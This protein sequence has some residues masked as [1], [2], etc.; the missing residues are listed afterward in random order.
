[1]KMK[2]TKIMLVDN[3]SSELY[4]ESLFQCIT[5][6]IGPTKFEHVEDGEQAIK[7]LDQYHLS[8]ELPDLILIDTILPGENGPQVC[9]QIRQKQYGDQIGII[10]LT[11]GRNIS[12]RYKW[13]N[14][15]ACVHKGD[16]NQLEEDIKRVLREYAR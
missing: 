15:D 5:T 14:A 10:G 8:Q 1:M 3:R 16:L 13:D 4:V 12:M 9:S 7:K 2:D 6:A 11:V